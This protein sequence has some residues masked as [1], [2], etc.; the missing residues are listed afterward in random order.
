[1]DRDR[2][3]VEDLIEESY[4]LTLSDA[5]VNLRMKAFARM[6]DRCVRQALSDGDVIDDLFEKLAT[7][8]YLYDKALSSEEEEEGITM[9]EEIKKVRNIVRKR[10]L[11]IRIIERFAPDAAR[12]IM[13]EMRG[14]WET[15][16]GEEGL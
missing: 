15:S 9:P 7:M 12:L 16:L 3:A 5:G 6:C 4:L 14:D 13:Q 10:R 11:A 8:M 1:M 2:E